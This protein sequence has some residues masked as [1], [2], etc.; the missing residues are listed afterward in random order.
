MRR[1]TESLSIGLVV[2][3]LAAAAEAVRADGES[4]VSPADAEVASLRFTPDPVDYDPSIPTLD[5]VTGHAFGEKMTTHREMLDYLRALADASDRVLLR[6]YGESW[7]GRSLHYLV[8]GSESNIER[9]EEL[10]ADAAALADPRST[11]SS[12]AKRLIETL[13]AIVWMSYCV[14]GN[15]ASGTDAGLL[16]AYHLV[17]AQG[18]PVVDAILDDCLVLIDPLQNPDGRERFVQHF[19]QTRGRWPD[20]DPFAAEHDEPWP[21][22]RVN[23]YL[24]DMNRDWHSLTQPESRGRV[25]AYLEWMP[26]VFADVHEM[27]GE[28]SYYFPP[29]ARPI[30]P[31][32]KG[33]LIEWTETFGKNHASWFDR[34]GFDYF[35]REVFDSF[36]P[37]YGESWPL[38]QGAVGMT[39]E[40]AGTGGLVRERRDETTQYYRDAVQR[41][42]IA[43]LSTCQAAAANRPSLLA[44]FHRIRSAAVAEGEFGEVREYYLVPGAD[45]S[46]ADALVTLLLDQ[47]I[48]VDRTI[49]PF[50]HRAVREHDSDTLQSRK[51]GA[52]TYR[53]S[54]AQP[55]KHL[56]K[57]LLEK[58]AEMASDFVDEQKERLADYRG[59]QIYDITGWSLPLTFGVACYRGE[60]VVDVEVERMTAPPARNGGIEDDRRAKV[61]Y[62]VP[63]TSASSAHL[64][65]RLL[66][67]G[68]RVLQT[69]ESFTIG[70]TEYPAGSLVV[71]VHDNERDV[72]DLHETLDALGRELGVRID[73]TDTSWVED[74]V[75]FGSGRVQYVKAPR[76]AM[77]WGPPTS[78]YSAGAARYLLEQRY[79]QPVTC[80]PAESF[81]RVD[82]DRYDVLLAPAVRGSY[83]SA[84]G[85]AGIAELR[86]WIG[87]GGTLV[88]LGSA[89]RWLTGEDVALLPVEREKKADSG[90]AEKAEK[91]EKAD[92]D[93]RTPEGS[94]G[95]A[96]REAIRPSVEWPTAIPGA[97]L[98]VTLDPDHWLAH[99]YEGPIHV[100]ADTRAIFTPIR[101]DAGR[102][103]GLFAP[104]DR[105][106]ASGVAWEDT[107]DQVAEKPYLIHRPVGRG[108]VIAFV[109]DPTFRAALRGLDLLLLN[110]VLRGPS[111]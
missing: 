38:F 81:G 10:R 7:E 57:T 111:H 1:L 79:D 94:D 18:D 95:Q 64:L 82:L 84:L 75:N 20:A 36:F 80:I 27:G 85:E 74:G 55:S 35:T 78:G 4:S 32:I 86:R 9:I 71:K 109:E 76:I 83:S 45:P 77:L 24:F 59:H 14:H 42:F 87:E 47:G 48:E 101:I 103:V 99:G 22:G 17:A 56:V 108:H 6:D 30:N 92:G 105:L 54:L 90:D 13:P 89:V 106:L 98:R 39:F 8:V 100:L 65:A 104:R 60:T 16:L 73:A 19:R 102:N 67:A 26:H 70:G 53:I 58:H 52:G 61:A 43:S 28:S 72:P 49:A 46:A 31:N 11:D 97:I 34:M 25:A 66:R 40:M 63:W 107:L 33:T 41:H 37:G 21:S 44:D 23:H 51:F 88:S 50:T 62:L 91:A 110:A 69:D 3:A 2:L 29:P 15:E 96:Y 93:A 12:E 68:I 5:A